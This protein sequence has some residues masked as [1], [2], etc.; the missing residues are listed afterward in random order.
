MTNA[1]ARWLFQAF[2]V[3][4]LFSSGGGSRTDF[5]LVIRLLSHK[6]NIKNFD[7]L[8]RSTAG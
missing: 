8:A 4:A 3:R 2:V 7:A 6:S 1:M 5:S